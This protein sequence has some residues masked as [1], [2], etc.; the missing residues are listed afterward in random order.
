MPNWCAN[1]L[2][3][4]A[5]TAES[6]AKLSEIVRELARAAAANESAAIFNLIKPVPEA[7]NIVAGWSGDAAEQAA[8]EAVEQNNRDTLG[9]T[10]WY[11]YC[12]GEWGTKWD[13]RDATYDIEGNKITIYFDTAWSPPIGIYHALENMGFDVEATYVEQG[14]A[15]IGYYR[16][17]VDTTSELQELDHEDDGPDLSAYFTQAGINHAPMHMGG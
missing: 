5:T 11:D 6:E 8:R 4:I 9:Y 13:A 10:N 2:K 15:Y 3:L 17:G 14:M 12:V 7:L 1:S 16:N